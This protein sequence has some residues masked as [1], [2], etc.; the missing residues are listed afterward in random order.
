MDIF[1]LEEVVYVPGS[2]DKKTLKSFFKEGDAKGW[3]VDNG[4]Q[5]I[6]H[7]KRWEKA[8][9]QESMVDVY[10]KILTETVE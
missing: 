1:R 9:E 5:E 8:S 7:M 6:K 3:L 10:V 2:K 4:Y